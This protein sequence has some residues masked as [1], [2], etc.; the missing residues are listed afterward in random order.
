M[1]FL[2][3]L[4]NYQIA[5]TIA[6]YSKKIVR[7]S[8]FFCSWDKTKKAIDLIPN[9][10]GQQR[11]SYKPQLLRIVKFCFLGPKKS[12]FMSCVF[13]CRYCILFIMH[14]YILCTYSSYLF[15]ENALAVLALWE[16]SSPR[17]KGR[18][19]LSYLRP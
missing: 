8:A 14:T 12:Y 3:K 6:K 7:L 2:V 10:Y 16:L 18:N 5:K 11:I 4:Q 1:H 15:W 9:L 19:A 17:E 13:F